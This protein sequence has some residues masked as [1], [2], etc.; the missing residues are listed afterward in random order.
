MILEVNLILEIQEGRKIIGAREYSFNDDITSVVIPSSVEYIG[1]SA[2]YGCPH[3]ESVIFSDKSK[4]KT[5]G[6]TSFR[7]CVELK[8]IFDLPPDANVSLTAFSNT[9]TI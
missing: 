3:L 4:L 6:D 9:L 1:V 5:I 8:N 2:F 7:A